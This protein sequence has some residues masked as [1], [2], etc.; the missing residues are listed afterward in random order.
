MR[1]QHGHSHSRGHGDW[2]DMAE[3]LDLDAL[4]L[5][6]HFHRIFGWIKELC[7]DPHS[8]VDLGA[9]TGGGTLGL[10]RTFPEATV[11]AVDQ[12]GRMLGRLREN[13]EHHQLSSRVST[14][15]AD[16]DEEWPVLGKV[17]LM[18]AA[19]SMHHFK[20]PATIFSN[21]RKS[22]AH[23]GV[24]VVVEMVALPRYLPVD[25][26]FGVPGFEERCHSA[27]DRA[28]FNAH[29]DWSSTLEAADFRGLAQRTFDYFQSTDQDLLA[30]SAVL[31]LARLRAHLLDGLTGEDLATLEQLLDPE[32][33]RGVARRNDLVMRGSHKV[34]VAGVVR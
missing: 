30:R 11:V 9:G 4:L 17:D 12:S 28:S 22:L 24:L 14:V 15:R 27:T 29:P 31:S 21:I 25:L 1:N 18:W 34:W 10:A 2:F 6:D 20:D 5:D 3:T 13:A 33:E 23:S 8:I 26:G 19:T 7:G 16:L 32:S